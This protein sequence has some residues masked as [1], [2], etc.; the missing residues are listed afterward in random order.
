[1]RILLY[2]VAA[3]WLAF[4]VVGVMDTHAAARVIALID[5]K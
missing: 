2:T 5:H 1:M 3:L 4:V